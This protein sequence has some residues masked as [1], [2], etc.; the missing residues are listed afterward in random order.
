MLGYKDIPALRS[1]RYCKS[2]LVVTRHLSSFVKGLS[3][4]FLADK[5]ATEGFCYGFG[6]GVDL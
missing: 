4:E 1:H 6:L 2:G 3:L 5:P